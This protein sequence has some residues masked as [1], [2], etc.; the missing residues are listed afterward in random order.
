MLQEE[1]TCCNH[2]GDP[3]TVNEITNHSPQHQS[4]VLLSLKLVFGTECWRLGAIF[5]DDDDVDDD[6]G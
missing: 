5:S 3:L 6:G 1:L 4:D 2:V